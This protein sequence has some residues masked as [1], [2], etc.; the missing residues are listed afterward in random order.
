MPP[1]N[2]RAY[3]NAAGNGST[4]AFRKAKHCLH[5]IRLWHAEPRVTNALLSTESF[6][7]RAHRTSNQIKFLHEKTATW[8]T[9]FAKPR[10]PEVVLL[11]GFAM[12]WDPK[13]QRHLHHWR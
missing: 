8:L 3:P 13:M 1:A 6:A 9:R 7:A 2:R 4:Y 5:P 11:P 12:R 10:V